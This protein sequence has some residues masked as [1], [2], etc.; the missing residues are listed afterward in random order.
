MQLGSIELLHINAQAFHNVKIILSK[1]MQSVL[2]LLGRGKVSLDADC[3][4][5]SPKSTLITS[6]IRTYMHFHA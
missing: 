4:V 1:I 2:A 6:S 3:P 5:L